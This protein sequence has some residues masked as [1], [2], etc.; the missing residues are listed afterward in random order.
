ML[1]ALICLAP[2]SP[3]CEEEAR[4]ARFEQGNSATPLAKAIKCACA[5]VAIAVKLVL[6]DRDHDG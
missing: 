6:D 3:P 5:E 2:V 4:D 1:I